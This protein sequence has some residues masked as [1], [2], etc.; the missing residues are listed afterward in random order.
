METSIWPARPSGSQRSWGQQSR[1]EQLERELAAVSRQRDIF[2][3]SLGHLGPGTAA[4]IQG[5]DN[6][7]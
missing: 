2:E 3:K 6:E 5:I 1:I 4:G 7:Q